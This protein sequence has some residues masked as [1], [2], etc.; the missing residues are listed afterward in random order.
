VARGALRPGAAAP[1]LCLRTA[2][3]PQRSLTS[4]T[5]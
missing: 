1:V 5:P 4:E 3:T 2:C